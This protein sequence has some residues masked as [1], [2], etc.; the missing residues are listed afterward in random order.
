MKT[1]IVTA[2]LS[3]FLTR[4]ITIRIQRLRDRLSN[5]PLLLVWGVLNLLS[6][7]G[8]NSKQIASKKVPISSDEKKGWLDYFRTK[9]VEHHTVEE[10]VVDSE[11]DVLDEDV[12]LVMKTQ[13]QNP[14]Q[15][16]ELPSID[17]SK[18]VANG[19]FKS[20]TGLD[21]VKTY[22]SADDVYARQINSGL[23]KRET[24]VS[25]INRETV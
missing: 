20:L 13:L 3:V 11:S 1:V 16:V 14:K 19:V 21:R 10:H 15:N 9:K 12:E 4:Y 2:I 18:I 17:I 25:N 8:R 5:N 23:P 22:I 6:G 24:F 7:N